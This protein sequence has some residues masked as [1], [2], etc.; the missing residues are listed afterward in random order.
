MTIK[1]F[2]PVLIFLWGT[3][4]VF[5]QVT[6]KV[7]A[8]PSNTPEKA[9]LYVSGDFNDWQASATELYRDAQGNYTTTLHDGEGS[10]EYKIT[11]GSWK[12]VEGNVSGGFREN[13]KL[14]FTGKPQT[15]DIQVESWEDLSPDPPRPTAENVSVLD[16][17]FYMPQLDKTRRIWL[18]LPPDYK[19]SDKTYPVIYMQDGQNLFDTNTSYAGSWEVEKTLNRL[20][21]EKNDYGVIVVGI[22]NGEQERV[23]EYTPWPHEKYG[24]GEGE[25][26]ITFIA[27]TLK[28]YIDK[29]YRTRKEAQYTALIGSSLGALIST[30][31]GVKYPARFQKI[32]ALSPAYWINLQELRQYIQKSKSDLS[33]MRIYSIAGAEE[34]VSG[35]QE[36]R[37]VSNNIQMIDKALRNKG[38]KKRNT[39]IQIDQDGEHN[40]KY[41]RREFGKIYQWL[42][43]DVKLK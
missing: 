43:K 24:G 15:I 37:F 42:F 30:Y 27:E 6:L 14:T 12:T 9:Q 29:H 2:L 40:E 16:S 18:Y 1:R 3:G 23:D 20:F 28:P 36:S 33:N 25:A 19:D 21:Q 31:G 34:A 39:K 5:A 11:R 38:L 22:D 8:L 26:Y 32:G 4:S 35:Y 10:V 17:A 41:W 7:T 13:R